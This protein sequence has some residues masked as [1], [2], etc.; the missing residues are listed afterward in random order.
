MGK[1]ILED[2]FQIEDCEIVITGRMID[3]DIKTNDLILL[4]D[5]NHLKTGIIHK[6]RKNGEIGILLKSGSC[7]PNKEYLKTFLKTYLKIIY[8]SDWREQKLNELGI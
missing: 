4:P 7:D 5:G 2:V 1:F 3:G 8:I 6:I